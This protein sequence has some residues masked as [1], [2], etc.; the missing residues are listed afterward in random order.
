MSEE[1]LSPREHAEMRDILLAGTHRIRP[2]G[3]HRM[4]LIAAAVALVLVGGVTGGVVTSAAILGT[5]N[6]GPITTPSPTVTEPTP[7]PTP[8]PTPSTPPVVPEPP[9]EGVLPFGGECENITTVAET[10]AVTGLPMAIADYRWRDGG[11]DVLG[12]VDCMWLSD[13]EYL[14]A[15][16]NVYAYPDSVV[17]SSVKDAVI[18]G[19]RPVEDRFVC[20]ASGAVDGTWLLVQTTSRLDF[21]TDAS[22]GT[23]YD[24]IAARIGQYDTPVPATRTAEWWAMPDC[25]TLAGQ[26][27][28]AVLGHERIEYQGDSANGEDGTHPLGIPNLAGVEYTCGLSFTSGA[29]DGISGTSAQL[30]FFAGGAVAFDTALASAGARRITVDGAVAAVLVHGNDRYEGSWDVLL[31]NDG[32]NVLAVYTDGLTPGDSYIPLAQS[33]LALMG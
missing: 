22:I 24:Q 21:G 16:V 1:Q 18:P 10:A 29:G 2:A 28:P 17:P 13:G 19:C 4:Q 9:A 27:D 31:V 26:I 7:T 15:I 5:Q 12:G 8:T 23:L 30:G 32:V 25:A 33:V 20:A 3:A 14:G 6:T 11:E